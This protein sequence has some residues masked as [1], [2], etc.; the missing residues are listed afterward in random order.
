MTRRTNI[1]LSAAA[2]A[3]AGAAGRVAYARSSAPSGAAESGMVVSS[4]FKE[5]D[6]RD[7]QIRV[8]QQALAADSGSAVAMVNLAALH[9]QRA[10]EG[11][12]WDDYLKAEQ[13][14]RHSLAIRTNRNGPAA[15]TLVATLL[16]QHRFPE[17]RDVAKD[18]VA[19]DPYVPQ[20]R[21]ML[22]E[23][24]M[25]LGDWKTA[26]D[27]LDPLWH[28][29]AILSIAPR[30]ARWAELN[31]HSADA[32]ALLDSARDE[33]ISR[34][35]VPS[36]T[37]AWFEFRSGDLALRTG[38]L[39]NA[40]RAFRAGLAIE[41]AD[42]RLLAAMARL[43]ANRGD[44]K[45]A[46]AWGERAVAVQLD[47]GT[48]GV[49]GD[50]YTAIGD[51][52]KAA[53]YFRT[54]EVAVTAQPGPFHRAW[55]LYLLDHGLRVNEVLAKSRAELSERHDIYGYDITAWALH[56]SQLDRAAIV[57]MSGALQ[58]G[59]PD[60]ILWYHD[61]MIAR[62][63]GANARAKQSLHKAL[64]LNDHWHPTQPAEARAVLDSIAR[65]R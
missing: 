61:G 50:A 34:T 62:A 24:A 4:G 43:S 5:R 38:R 36:E 21:S 47:P 45:D 39:R 33:A 56:R 55:S 64:E 54:M 51:T 49:V 15:V 11:G 7:V 18:L 6:L 30:L 42:P 16:A 63:L 46:I 10:R 37:K 32:R 14:A 58:L 48:L 17:A 23:V 44:P 27:M 9:N 35:D 53:E 8:W 65:G 52:A 1:L 13:Y 19:D 3:L 28:D 40:E 22:G 60:P 57:L 25:E 59:T 12:S 20:Y 29:R 31:G 2:L 26:H 41:P